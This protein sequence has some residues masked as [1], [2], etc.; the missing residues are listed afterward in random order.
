M[1]Q[2]I[3]LTLTLAFFTL[4]ATAQTTLRGTVTDAETG[5]PLIGANVV[6]PGT[7]VGTSTDVDGT[8]TLN[9]PAGSTELLLTYTGYQDRTVEINGATTLDIIMESGRVIDEVIV[10]GYGKVKKSD[11]TGAISSVKPEE[12]DVV[13]YDDFQ[14]FLQGRATGV[15]VQSNGGG[16][17]DPSSIRIRGANSLRGDNEPLYVVDGIIINSATEDVADPLSG[18]SY[19]A[20]QNGLSGI[21]PQDIQSIEILK[22]ASATAI[23]GSRGANGVIII[24][25]KQ[26]ASEEPQFNYK[27]ITRTGRATNLYDVLDSR[28][29]VQYQ[30][31]FRELQGFSPR[32]YTYADGSIA[33][34]NESEEF[35]LENADSIPRLDP[36]D[37]YDDIFQTS[38]T[39]NHRLSVRGGSK[40]SNYYLA[41]GFVDATDI[42]PGVRAQQGDFLINLR[43]QLGDRI[44]I[45]P[46]FST[47]YSTARGAKGTDNLGSFNTS[48]IRQITTSAPL[49]GFEENN[50]IDAGEAL[51]GPRAWLTDYDDDSREIRTLAS[52]RLDY[53]I[54][55]WLT[56]R[57]LAG[58]DYRNK[59]RQLWYGNALNRGQLANGEAGISTLNRLRY[60]VDNT[61]MFDRKLAKKNKISGTVGVV[62]DGTNLEQ[63]ASSASDFANQSLRY[64][65]ISF[66][67]NFTPVQYFNADETLLSFLG[68]IN[69]SLRNRYLFTVS[70]RGDGSSKFTEGNRFGF[71]PSAA[72][73]WKLTKEKWLRDATWLSEAKFRVGYGR[74]GSQ[75]IRP[76]QTFSRFVPTANLL[77]DGN[78]GGVSAVIPQN[79]GNPGLTWETT[80]QFNVGIDFGLLEDRFV[81]NLDYYYKNTT[82]LLQEFFIG[83]SA[84]FTSIIANRGDLQNQ[85][86]EF[87]LTAYLTGPT[88]PFKWNVRGN[89]SANRN[90]I[91]NL[92]T[93]P[94]QFG[95]EFVS[96][97]VGRTVS[98]GSAFKAPANIYIEGQPAGLFYGY[99][100]NGIIT[101]E[102]QL[103][104][105]PAVQGETPQLG[106]ILYVDQ[107]GDGVVND[108]DLTIIGDPN[109]DFIVG[110]GSEM[111]YKNWSLDLFLNGVFGNEIAN[112]NLAREGFALGN[113]N[114]IRTEVY[115][116]AYRE[117][118]TNPSHPRLGY[119]LQGDFTDRLVEDGSFLRLTYINLGYRIQPTWTGIDAINV[120]V[121]GQNL[122]LLTNYTGFDPE[123]NSFAFDPTRQGV[124]WG[125]FPNQRAVTI[126]AS[127]DF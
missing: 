80:D 30:N 93:P 33:Q 12:E 51:D 77:A 22:D 56:Y 91:V 50:L 47:T 57:F 120:Y 32:F 21:N 123:V 102:S 84:G 18:S 16:I 19:L 37:W 10:I 42:I 43:Q 104:T 94:A 45:N 65:G 31:E 79:L 44:E 53:K 114:N 92:G 66:G 108:R 67:Q 6:V 115:E 54:N 117:G 70:F 15:Y 101:S 99:A 38:F 111:R 8:Y 78:G 1:K 5:E 34:F 106:D 41:G 20:P 125:S 61:L 11:A 40:K 72:F 105:A 36:I 107:N 87:G 27:L 3:L 89:F 126:G 127:V 76:Y 116:G 35:M 100:T 52:F 69:Y 119:P 103:E 124:D 63:T 29:Y 59:Q 118:A 13:Q 71:F 96:A 58:G 49:L 23:Y 112:G 46:R 122:L 9:V 88:S 17:L 64:E 28:D 55:D 25:T 95:T 48:I 81:G 73:A 24:T 82:D 4:T 110:F 97:F 39:Q 60:N 86:I 62:L 98:G 26:G 109:P 68:R 74:T 83:P 7:S 2:Q 121:S 90:K 113:A 75:A 85:G 14:S